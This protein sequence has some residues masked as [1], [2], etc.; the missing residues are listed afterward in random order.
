MIVAS[1]TSRQLIALPRGNAQVYLSWRMVAGDPAACVY[2]LQRRRPGEQWAELPA[3][4]SDSTNVLDTTPE[5]GTYEYRVSRDGA[6]EASEAIRVDSG[7]EATDVALRGPLPVSAS[8]CSHTAMGDLDNDGRMDFV[9]RF[10][11]AGRVWFAGT[12]GDGAHMWK[13]CTNLP[14]SGGWNGSTNHV[15]FLCW[16]VDGDG[17]TEV[18]YHDGGDAWPEVGE[19]ET[20]RTGER[21]VVADGETGQVKFAVS[22]PAVKSRVMMTVG[23][24]RGLDRPAAVVVLDETYGDETLTAIDGAGGKV[25]WKVQQPRPAGHN[26]DIGDIDHDGVQEVICGGVCYNGDGTVRWKAE[27]FGHTDM[28]KP[29]RIDPERP[30]LQI[31]Y[32]VERDNPGVYLVDKDGATIFSE[33]YRHA[34]FGWIAKLTD[35]NPGLQLHC[36]EDARHEYGAAK[37]GMREKANAHFPVFLNDGTHW[38]ELTNDQRKA[39][40]PVQWNEGHT[41][42]VDRKKNRI[43]SLSRSGKART[44]LELPPGA[45]FG[46]NLLLA[47]IVGDFR[48]NIVTVDRDTN[49]LIVLANA[50]PATQRKASPME[51]F[52]YRHDRSQHGSGYYMYVPPHE[53]ADAPR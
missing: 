14:M 11:E 32:N 13:V 20:G 22:W 17:R 10:T 29:A 49:E 1:H 36:S 2:K 30:G 27:P 39:L 38:L 25:L 19:Y 24:L 33:P 42:F 51:S 6:A 53:G 15:P 5:P 50:V 31:W 35:E 18:V 37:A 4:V 44:L 45:R 52:Y 43:V 40:M 46:R 16:D 48:E 21:L 7:V 26:L 28:S 8:S 34:H 47:D 12:R 23:H 3:R 9:T 41:V